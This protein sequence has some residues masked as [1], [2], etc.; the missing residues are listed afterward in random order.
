[1]GKKAVAIIGSANEE[2]LKKKQSEK[3]RQKKLRA[4][5]KTAK[6][7]GLA[8][9]QRVVDTTVESLAELEVIEK[10]QQEAAGI[11]APSAARRR[12]AGRS[13]P[14]QAAKSKVTIDHLYPISDAIKLLREISLAKFDSTVELHLILKEKGISKEIELPHSTGKTRKIGIADDEFI[15]KLESGAVNLDLDSLYA[16]PDQM[17]KL[18]KFAKILG[19]KGLMPNPKTDTVVADPAAAIKKF[20]DKSIVL[21]TEKDAPLIHTVVGKLSMTDAQ[22]TVNISAILK[23]LSQISKA[24][25]KSTMSPAIKLALQN[26]P[27]VP[28]IN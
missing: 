8:G 5:G 6:A 21:K 18:V 28:S 11:P 7:P 24:V 23:S 26:S 16:S 19:P 15:K 3:L 9:G 2:E 4:S 17:G 20:S 13:K 25:L 27:R 14:Y 1:M 22:L 10:K 12:K